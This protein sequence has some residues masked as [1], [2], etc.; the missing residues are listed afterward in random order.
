[1]PLSSIE[2]RV[3]FLP[4]SIIDTLLQMLIDAL[5]FV[6]DLH[7]LENECA[8]KHFYCVQVYMCLVF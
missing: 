8:E 3:F 7:V 2:V 1:M 6:F 4:L 5:L